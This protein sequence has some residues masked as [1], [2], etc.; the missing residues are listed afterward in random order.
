MGYFRSSS[1]LVAKCAVNK[2]DQSELHGT[3]RVPRLQIRKQPPYR[4]LAVNKVDPSPPTRRP[5][6]SSNSVEG[7]VDFPLANDLPKY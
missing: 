7:V 5:R 6:T 3:N 4:W 2:T 1:R